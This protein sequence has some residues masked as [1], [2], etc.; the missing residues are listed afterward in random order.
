[1]VLDYKIMFDLFSQGWQFIYTKAVPHMVDGFTSCTRKIIW[2]ADWNIV[3]HEIHH[4][5]IDCPNWINGTGA[6]IDL[7]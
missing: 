2:F 1:M 5:I 7:L 6:I 4:A 3:E